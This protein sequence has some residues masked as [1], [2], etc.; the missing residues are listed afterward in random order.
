MDNPMM[1]MALKGGVVGLCLVVMYYGQKREERMAREALSREERTAKAFE[2][3]NKRSLDIQ[4]KT[5]EV[6]SN[7]DASTR[8][9]HEDVRNRPCI[10]WDGEERR[11]RGA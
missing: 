6:L 11:K 9:L 7:I 4:Q 8:A 2:D 5:I 10:D 1:E 3:L